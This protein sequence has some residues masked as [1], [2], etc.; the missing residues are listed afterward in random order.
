MT[1]SLFQWRA[2]ICIFNCR[3]SVVS[4]NCERRLSRNFITMLKILLICYYYFGNTSMSFLTLLYMLILEKKSRSK[5]TKKKSLSVYHWN[6]NS[7]PAHNFWRLTQLKAYISMY[8]QDFICLSE[9]Y[10][11]SSVHDTKCSK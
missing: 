9:T 4:T 1:V 7:L 2:V 11:D 10:L 8:K 3:L 5:K 6:L